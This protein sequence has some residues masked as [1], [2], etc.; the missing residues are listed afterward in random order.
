MMTGVR[1]MTIVPTTDIARKG[2]LRR[3]ARPR[4]LESAHA[5][6]VNSGHA[7]WGWLTVAARLLPPPPGNCRTASWD[8]QCGRPLVG[9]GANLV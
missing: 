6:T 8:H 5:W 3:D 9:R 7:A 2:G 4:G 1:I